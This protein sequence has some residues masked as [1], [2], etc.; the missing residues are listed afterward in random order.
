M[1]E[2]IIFPNITGKKI[3]RVKSS[4]IYLD[5]ALRDWSMAQFYFHLTTFYAILRS[6]PDKLMGVILMG[7]SVA[8][9]FFLP[10]LDRNPVKSIR[11]RSF[12]FKVLVALFVVSFLILGYLGMKAPTELYTQIARSCTI[13]YFVVFLAMPIYTKMEKNKPVPERVT[14]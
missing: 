14:M 13:Y 1:M 6:V 7:L 8:I 4:N 9:L 11:Y 12:M 10:W 5:P 2:G 3:L